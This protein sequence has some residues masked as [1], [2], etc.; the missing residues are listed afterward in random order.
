MSSKEKFIKSFIRFLAVCVIF[1]VSLF[2]LAPFVAFLTSRI[3]QINIEKPVANL[4]LTPTLLNFQNKTN[5]EKISIEGSSSGNVEVELFLNENSVAK[6]NSSENGRFKFEN[7][8]ILKGNNKLTLKAIDIKGISSD[9]SREYLIEYDNTK[10][11]IKSINL[12]QGEEIKNL[13]KNIRII[14]ETSEPCDILINGKKV[15]IISEN[16]FE[17]LLGVEEGNVKIEIVIKDKA[18]N[19]EK[20]NY[21]VTYKR[22]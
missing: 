17:Y 9:M 11:E 8:E 4:V 15:F 7:I 10:P 2:Y 19:E 20:V 14:G 13:N 6:T 16:K 22:G 5:Q 21:N 3:F 1:Y 18:G 12:K